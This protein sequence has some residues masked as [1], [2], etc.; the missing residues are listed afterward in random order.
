MATTIIDSLLVTLG[1]DPKNFNKGRDQVERDNDKLRDKTKKQG[2][3]IGTALANLG[4]Q[5]A[6]LFL[7]FETAKGALSWF[8]GLNTSAANLG[9]FSK[10]VGE[11]VHEVNAWDNAVEL[12]GGTAKEAEGDLLSLSNS[13]TALRA[14]GEVSPLVLLLQRM[15]VSLYDAQGHVRK[16]TDIYKDLGDKLRAYNRADAFNLAR[17]A[18]VSESTFNLIRAEAD[19]RQRMLDIGERNA[20]LDAQRTDDAAEFQREWRDITQ[21]ITAAGYEIE[22]AVSPALKAVFGE[23]KDINGEG[24]ILKTFIRLLASGAIV[25]KSIFLQ[26]GDA[27][28]GIAAAI[29]AVAHGNFREAWNILN[30]QS[31]HAKQ[32][33]EQAGAAINDAF[34][35]APARRRAAEPASTE[36]PRSGGTPATMRGLRNNNPGNLRYAGQTGATADAQ[37]FAVFP[38]LAA[39]IQ[40]ANRQLDLYAARGVNTIGEIVKRWAPSSENDTGAYVGR[41]TKTLGIGADQQLTPADRQRLLQALFNQGE[42]NRVAPAATANA[43]GAQNAAATARFAA[44]GAQPSPATGGSGAAAG[45]TTVDIG[46]IVVHTQATDAQGVAAE[47]PGALKRKGVVAQADAGMS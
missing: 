32:Q 22:H 28:G 4:K 31:A 42:G 10:N 44:A 30:D 17:G 33:Q 12:A 5:A 19:E 26:V 29:G 27:I 24:D 7:G 45:S 36:P 1:L 21:Q 40:A 13:I 11:S 41:L 23:M 37:G 39:G 18:G 20:A 8:V 14:T 34:E 25:V 6:G 35:D 3:E 16:L 15:N 43:L 38:S 47:I 2:D 9:R 46:Q